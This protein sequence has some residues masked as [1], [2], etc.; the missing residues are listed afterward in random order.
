[1][2]LVPSRDG[3]GFFWSVVGFVSLVLVVGAF[4]IG[5]WA[6]F[7]DTLDLK[8]WCGTACERLDCYDFG[9]SWW[10]CTA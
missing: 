1:M 2:V 5:L 8:S 7:G 4:G 9:Q 3:C 10:N 6:L